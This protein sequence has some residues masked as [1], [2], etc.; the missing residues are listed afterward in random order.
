MKHKTNLSFDIS[1][2]FFYSAE[3]KVKIL[4]SSKV[5]HVE[6]DESF[7]DLKGYFDYMNDFKYLFTINIPATAANMNLRK[8]NSKRE[9]KR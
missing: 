6:D 9:Y 8:V 5:N 1:R 7:R 4:C 3:A 2:I